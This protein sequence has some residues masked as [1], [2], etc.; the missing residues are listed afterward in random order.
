MLM[1]NWGALF[2]LCSY[3][4]IIGCLTKWIH[5]I[6]AILSTKLS[7][8]ELAAQI[9]TIYIIEWVFIFSSAISN[10]LTILV[11]NKL[12]EKKVAEA[13]A[14]TRVAFTLALMLSILAGSIIYI[15]KTQLSQIFSKDIEVQKHIEEAIPI[16]ALMSVPISL[17][18]ISYGLIY[19]MGDQK[20]GSIVLFISN[21]CIK[22]PLAALFIYVLKL[23]LPG[24]CVSCFVA[25]TCSGLGLT[26]LVFRK[27]WREVAKEIHAKL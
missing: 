15:F 25:Y 23:G 14:Y 8:A 24:L 16:M 26:F 9:S 21:Y 22:A 17:Y 5:T 1:E 19:A 12:G 27:D 6:I 20:F 13:K 3:C 10:A 7:P 4:C 2:K 11:A 18:N